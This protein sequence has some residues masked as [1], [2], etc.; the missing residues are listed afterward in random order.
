[1]VTVRPSID[2]VVPEAKITIFLEDGVF[3]AIDWAA[4]VVVSRNSSYA[5]VFNAA[6]TYVITAGGG[7]IF[8]QA[9]EHTA[10]A[11]LNVTN[12]LVKIK[13]EGMFIT[14]IKAGDSLNDD[15]MLV[16]GNAL[17]HF[18]HIED[19]GF[20]GNRANQDGNYECMD[21]DRCQCIIE[22][23][24]FNNY[25]LA[26]GYD[27]GGWGG[28]TIHECY[29]KNGYSYGFNC[30]NARGIQCVNNRL[31]RTGTLG[32]STVMGSMIRASGTTNLVKHIV[33]SMNYCHEDANASN[34][35]NPL[36]CN[37]SIEYI[38]AI[39]NTIR[40]NFIMGLHAIASGSYR[41][42]NVTF[43]GNTIE[44]EDP[45]CNPIDVNG[46][47]K[48]VIMGNV[49]SGATA[50][51]EGYGIILVGAT[52][53]GIVA[54]N[55]VHTCEWSGIASANSRYVI[56]SS[57][58]VFNTNTNWAATAAIRIYNTGTETTTIRAHNNILFDDQGTPTQTSGFEL[59]PTDAGCTINASIRDNDLF[60]GT[61]TVYTDGGGAGTL[62]IARRVIYL[63][64][65]VTQITDTDATYGFTNAHQDIDLAPILWS[66]VYE[67]YYSAALHTDNASYIAY[68]QLRNRTDAEMITGS[69]VS[70]TSTSAGNRELSSGLRSYFK[71]KT[72]NRKIIE[73]EAKV[74]AGGTATLR[75]CMLE[76]QYY[77]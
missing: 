56:I 8:T 66:Q 24:Y 31:Y 40:G 27:G 15:I 52:A 67:I 50:D 16:D 76:I 20:E 32:G 69:E 71:G 45:S 12:P 61:T 55:I 37:G 6:A 75:G 46:A 47:Q 74:E 63:V 57:N 5:T 72:Q 68:S 59:K 9:G 29:F 49:C 44:G 53:V 60:E 77:G 28:I 38:T 13:G 41:P 19:I 48:V 18:F 25:G 17:T 23:V 64:F 3:L 7:E 51:T 35:G 39:G 21:I 22:R 33:F 1:M 11:K 36:H 73:P 10:T 54:L 14:K 58:I 70:T 2:K 42:Q 62:N 65:P 26:G 30:I 43:C 4:R 34:E